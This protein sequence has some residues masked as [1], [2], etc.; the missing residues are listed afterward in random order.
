[1]D[2]NA[3]TSE[4]QYGS[5]LPSDRANVLT[6]DSN[7]TFWTASRQED[8]DSGDVWTELFTF[9][10]NGLSIGADIIATSNVGLLQ[11]IQLSAI[12]FTR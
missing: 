3:I 6:V 12:E 4:P 7:E 10:V 9:S 5:N 2:S 1:M 11:G 8:E